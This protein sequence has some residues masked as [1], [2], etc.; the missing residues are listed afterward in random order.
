MALSLHIFDRQND[1]VFAEFGGQTGPGCFAGRRMG[2]GTVSKV[3]T[4][5]DTS[6][7]SVSTSMV[8]SLLVVS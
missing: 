1:W 5:K 6:I 4:R 8:I 3:P 7:I 2:V